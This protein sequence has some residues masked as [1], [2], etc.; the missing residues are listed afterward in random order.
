MEGKI[1]YN[2]HFLKNRATKRYLHMFYDATFNTGTYVFFFLE[3]SK[4]AYN[5]F[6]KS[7][8][9]I[10]CKLTLL[11]QNRSLEITIFTRY[12]IAVYARKYVSVQ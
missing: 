9:R 7:N 2:Y 6:G 12:L 5:V 10:K 1:V 11:I 4:R 3:S 8:G